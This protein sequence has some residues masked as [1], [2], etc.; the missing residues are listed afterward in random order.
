M[1]H[2]CP[3]MSH[4]SRSAFLHW[5]PDCGGTVTRPSSNLEGVVTGRSSSSSDS[6]QAAREGQIDSSTRPTPHAQRIRRLFRF[7]TPS[8][9]DHLGVAPRIRQPTNTSGRLVPT[10]DTPGHHRRTR[11]DGSVEGTAPR[12]GSSENHP[13]KP[14]FF[15]LTLTSLTLAIHKVGGGWSE[16]PCAA[17]LLSKQR[18]RS[19]YCNNFYLAVLQQCSTPLPSPPAP[20]RNPAAHDL[21][22]ED[23][24]GKILASADSACS[25]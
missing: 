20:N 8:D 13:M 2:P 18:Q 22:C 16:Q 24:G 17:R 15:G 1:S 3:M 4:P 7:W 6:S 21:R 12:W 11:S 5:H 25:C 19:Q 9:S 10:P 14:V 23:V